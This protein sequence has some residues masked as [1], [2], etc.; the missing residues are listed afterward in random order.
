MALS[1][2][3]LYNDIWGNEDAAFAAQIAQ[4]LQPRSSDT[5]Y[6]LFAKT[7]VKAGDYV[8]DVGCRDAVHAI[9]LAER[10][11]CRVLGVDIIPKHIADAQARIAAAGLQAQIR[12]QVAGIEAL[13]LRDGEVNHIWCRDML[14]HVDLPTGLQECSRVLAPGGRMLVYQTFATELLEPK[15]A[16][17]LFAAMSIVPANMQPAYFEATA[18]DA[19]F[20]ILERDP[21]DSE[22]REQW[23]E[24]G[25]N[26]AVEDLL[27][28]ARMRRREPELLARFGRNRYEANYASNL[29][30]IY[31][32]LGKLCP[33]SYLLEKN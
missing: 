5:L 31:Q 7:G 17:R 19:D 16:Q 33:T 28:L 10:Y 9:K 1:V 25:E 11:G 12:V 30:G 8:L 4:S 27:A 26:W 20:A 3:E 18:A 13:P 14:N 15:E 22:W 23:L 2:H 32:M 29:W 6:D 21:I 24:A